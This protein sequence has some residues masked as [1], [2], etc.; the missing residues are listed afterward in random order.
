MSAQ[1]NP[2]SCGFGDICA[3]YSPFWHQL[4][5]QSSFLEPGHLRPCPSYSRRRDR[6][7]LGLLRSLYKGGG[8]TPDKARGGV[9]PLQRVTPPSPPLLVLTWACP[10]TAT[11]CLCTFG[12]V[13]W[14]HRFGGSAPIEN[15]VC[16][17]C[18]GYRKGPCGWRSVGAGVIPCASN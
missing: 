9:L 14:N 17:L 4:T 3:L 5:M 12:A 7:N 13:F 8:G 18:A 10:N 1:L 15:V 6:I 2:Q 11:S 16:S